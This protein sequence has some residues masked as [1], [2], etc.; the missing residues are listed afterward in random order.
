MLE[1]GLTEEVHGDKVRE[2]EG[3]KANV[4]DVSL[5]VRGVLKEGKRLARYVRSSYS[6][7]LLGSGGI[8]KDLGGLA[9]Y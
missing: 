6:C 4:T 2:A 7:F 3:V 8:R 1:L 5:E 9:D